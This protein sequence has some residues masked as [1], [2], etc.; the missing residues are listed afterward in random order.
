MEPSDPLASLGIEHDLL[1]KR[2]AALQEQKDT[3]TEMYREVKRK[4]MELE[5]LEESDLLCKVCF[6][7]IIPEI[8][9]SNF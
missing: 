7:W 8:R 4:N 5:S 9:W 2:C 3:A 6:K 1:L